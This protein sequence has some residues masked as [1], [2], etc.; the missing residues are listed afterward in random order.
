MHALKAVIG[1]LLFA[2]LYRVAGARGM[3]A[4]LATARS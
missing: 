4:T 1:G 2:A 3:F